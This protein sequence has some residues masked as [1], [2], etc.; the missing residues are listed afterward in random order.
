M[1]FLIVAACCI[2][3]L[4]IGGLFGDAGTGAFGF[5]SGAAIGLAFARLRRLSAR[6]D[7]LQRELDALTR[8]QR[9]RGTAPAPTSAGSATR[10]APWPEVDAASAPGDASPS[11][12]SSALAPAAPPPPAPS[13]ADAPI[14]STAPRSGL[15]DK[16]A[17]A[18][19]RWFSEG[20]VPVKVGVLVLFAG[21][22]A[23]L[24]YAADEG[25]LRL[26]IELRLAGIALAAIA[27]LAF[28]WRERARRPSFGLAVQGGAI[29]VLLL[30]V[31]AA[32]R[33]YHLLPAGAAFTLLLLLVAGAGVLAVLQDALALAVLGILAGF[34]APILIATGAG[35]PVVLFS[36]YAL[37]NL[38]IFAIAWRKP[39]RALNLLGFFFTFAIGTAWG[40]LRYEHALFA[41]TEPFLLLNFAIYLAIPILYAR[42]REPSARDVVDGTLVFGNPL[43]AFALQAA[44]LDGARLPLAYCALALAALYAVLAWRLLPRR[45]V[46]GESFAVLATGFATLAVPLALSARVSA[47]AFALEGAA[48]V[49]L[50]LR[51]SRRLPQFSGLALQ[52][53]AAFAFALAL[54]FGRE[55]GVTLPIA[56]GVFLSALLLAAS[57]FA[58][59][60]LYRRHAA[61]PRLA[62]LLYLWGLAWWLGAGLHEIDRWLPLRWHAQALLA[63]ATV[64]AALAALAWTRVRASAAAW[65]AA[66]ALGAGIP[67]LAL[68]ADIGALPF[69]GWGLAAFAVYAAGGWFALGT[70]RE[71]ADATPRIAQ[72]GW[73]WTWTL[74]LALALR[75]FADLSLGSGWRDALT[76]LPLLA[77]WAIALLRPA[78]LAPP[79]PTRFA[80]HRGALLLSQALLALAA[81]V[82]LLWNAGDSAPLVWLPLLNP[83]DL[84]QIG[85]LACTTRWL[86][87]RAA[88]REL[89]ARRGALL[90]AAGFAFLT[91]ATLRGAHHLGGV[92]WD[93]QLG[94]SSLAQTALTVVWS[95]LGVLGWVLGSRRAQRALWLA[96]AVLMGVVLAKLLLVDRAHL[97]NLFG[98]VSFIAYGVLCTLIGYLAP[99]PPRSS[100]KGAAG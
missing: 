89:A 35:D 20:N 13:R 19:K 25:W 6:V 29:G 23:L 91:V 52:L 45:R 49:W 90:A 68:F 93:A 87:D 33:L 14:P 38:A 96:G 26:P 28:G 76:L 69:A 32:F 63:F 81:F 27:A 58:S 94:A 72:I 54:R 39:W 71:A 74:A 44:L 55:T 2:G 51:Q 85:V 42:R 1:G 40:V 4:L 5:F 30:S 16:L 9:T 73:C 77:A 100:G 98:I 62:L 12:D 99:A 66:L 70:L 15:V 83:I 82:G 78:W 43:L 21:V 92:P 61:Q 10:G 97:G 53:L 79:L 24:K 8:T 17:A 50:G 80:E 31:F 88:P 95:A 41:S 64:T 65:T 59:A 34:A 57:A 37:L 18:L 48:L 11:I 22:A 75:Q 67:V 46:L 86:A 3:G 47:C 56:N 60:W 36:Y 84:V 7:A